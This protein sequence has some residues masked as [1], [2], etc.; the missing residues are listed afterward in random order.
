MNHD[1]PEVGI[2]IAFLIS[3]SFPFSGERTKGDDR[4][5]T[6]TSSLMANPHLL[7]QDL[8]TRNSTSF[9]VQNQQQRFPCDCGQKATNTSTRAGSSTSSGTNTNTSTNTSS[10]HSICKFD[11][12][13]YLPVS[14]Q[15]NTNSFNIP[16][17]QHRLPH[18]LL[19][20]HLSNLLHKLL[21]LQLKQLLHLLPHLMLQQSRGIFFPFH[22]DL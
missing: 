9:R 22:F 12:P 7:W 2:L 21:Q 15:T 11:F 13:S 3:Y 4:E 10:H 6:K 19:L 14:S 8:A 20:P 16:R 17:P 1:S 18:Q 5:D